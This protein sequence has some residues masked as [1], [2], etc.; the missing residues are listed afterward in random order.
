MVEEDEQKEV[1]CIMTVKIMSIGK[2]FTF[3]CHF[4]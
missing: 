3:Y 4:S 2:I 1:M